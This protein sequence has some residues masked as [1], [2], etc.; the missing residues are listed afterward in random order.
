MLVECTDECSFGRKEIKLQS[1]HVWSE[2][3]CVQMHSQSCFK[4]KWIET[5]TW[6]A[7]CS[8]LP[9]LGD[10]YNKR[11]M[12]NLLTTAL[13]VVRRVRMCYLLTE[14]VTFM[15]TGGFEN[16]STFS[17]CQVWKSWAVWLMMHSKNRDVFNKLT[18]CCLISVHPTHQKEK[19]NVHHCIQTKRYIFFSWH[20]KTLLLCAEYIKIWLLLPG[21]YW[22]LYFIFLEEALCAGLYRFLGVIL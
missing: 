18:I 1:G 7:L 10:V 5:G 4:V 19:R 22:D 21:P 14:C 15:S 3:R 20:D 11:E 17:I 16:H 2:W 12:N 6:D 13:I 8:L 9:G